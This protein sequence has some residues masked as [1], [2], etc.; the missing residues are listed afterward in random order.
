MSLSET[1]SQNVQNIVESFIGKIVEKYSVDR[2]EVLSLWTGGTASVS[3]K[4]K[5]K[6]KPKTELATVDMDD[7]SI[8]R[9]N[10]CNKG[11]LVALC[12]SRGCK[13]T[14]TKEVL[15]ARLLGKED[16]PSKATKAVKSSEKTAPKT[17]VKGKK[18]ERAAATVDVVKK[19]TADIPVIPIRRNVHNNLE[20]P[21]TGLV[22]DRKT[23]MVIGKQQ[24]DGT[25]ADLT[26]E[27]IEACKRFKFK[28]NIPD[29]LDKKDNLDNV[30]IEELGDDS[31][32]EVEIEADD[33]EEVEID[34]EEGEEEDEDIEEDD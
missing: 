33:D 32:I 13:C 14:G 28:Y 26:D 24:E 1:L 10:S 16:A 7:I 20:H 34:D 11:E 22:F 6:P 12:K 8:E 15:I 25:I 30:K 27:D 4:P 31:D 19:L 23:E 5:A 18:A 21:E 29:N 17:V 9:L 3:T 2:E